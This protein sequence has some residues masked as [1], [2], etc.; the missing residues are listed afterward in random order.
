MSKYE[1]LKDYVDKIQSEYQ[2]EFEDL[3]NE[4]AS[5]SSED[6]ERLRE[7]VKQLDYCITDL[8]Q[9]N[10]TS[11]ALVDNEEEIRIKL[12]GFY[13]KGDRFV[14]LVYENIY[15]IRNVGS[16]RY[17]VGKNSKY[18]ITKYD[19]KHIIIYRR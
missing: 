3:K 18:F 10:R 15:K 19:I 12:N 4:L 6:I 13:D 11:R 16:Y 7:I 9:A 1:E 2:A 14:S 17:R 5:T 8:G